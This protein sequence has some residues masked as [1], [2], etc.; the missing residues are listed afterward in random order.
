MYQNHYPKTCPS[1]SEHAMFFCV[2][3]KNRKAFLMLSDRLLLD[4]CAGVIHKTREA[5]I[6]VL[7]YHECKLQ[8]KKK[9]HHQCGKTDSSF[10]EWLP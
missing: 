10:I 4:K 7:F 1:S 8:E 3:G 5:I 6:I 2:A 9:G